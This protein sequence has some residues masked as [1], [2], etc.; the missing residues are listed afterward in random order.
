M[1]VRNLE[2]ASSLARVTREDSDDAKVIKVTCENAQRA[3]L[4][5][6]FCCLVNPIE[7]FQ[8]FSEHCELEVIWRR[9]PKND[10][11]KILPTASQ[12]KHITHRAMVHNDQDTH[13]D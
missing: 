13:P 8:A 4:V 10:E 9:R 7:N 1:C 3:V 2:E 5:T 6:C 11:M 12:K